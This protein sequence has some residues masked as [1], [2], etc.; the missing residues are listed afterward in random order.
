MF[1]SDR[2]KLKAMVVSVGR[3]SPNDKAKMFWLMRSYYDA[4][5]E[6][7][8]LSDLSKKDAVILLK[9]RDYTVQGFSTLANVCV[10]VEGKRLRA[11]FSGDTVIDKRYWRQRALGKPFLSYMFRERIKSPFSPLYWLLISKGYKTY[12]MMANNFSEHYPR[13]E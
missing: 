1:K 7:R 5:T 6:A 13:F 11:V 3:L 10:E 2:A 8:F 4:I 9:D 12:L